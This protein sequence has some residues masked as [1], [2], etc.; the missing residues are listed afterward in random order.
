MNEISE[1]MYISDIDTY[2]LLFIN[3]AG[4]ETFQCDEREGVKCYELI[5]GRDEPC[6][7]CTSPLLKTDENYTWEYTNPITKRHYLLKDRLVEWEG[8]PAR[9][10]KL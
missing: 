4:R 6:P 1:L 8:R 5:Q 9:M 3:N 2:E 7:F 10:E